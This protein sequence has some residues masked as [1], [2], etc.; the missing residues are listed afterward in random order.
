M[1]ISDGKKN[2]DSPTFGRRKVGNWTLH[3]WELSAPQ[4]ECG[5]TF[6]GVD[7]DD[8]LCIEGYI[9][10]Y[11]DTYISIPRRLIEEL[12]GTHDRYVER[13]KR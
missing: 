5:N 2:Q 10:G 12:F 7:D 1:D 3:E 8:D 11:G 6:V 9:E 4:A 13:N